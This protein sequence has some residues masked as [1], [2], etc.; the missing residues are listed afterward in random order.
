MKK[1]I[2]LAMLA[3]AVAGC[4]AKKDVVIGNDKMGYLYGNKHV[5]D[6]RDGEVN[7]IKFS[8]EGY[9]SRFG[10]PGGEWGN[11]LDGKSVSVYFKF[12]NSV[13][14][15]QSKESLAPVIKFLKM[16]GKQTITAEGN[17]D[18]RGAREYN[19]ALGQRRAE[20]VKS[21][22]VAQGVNPKQI[23]TMSFGE[24]RPECRGDGE[25][26]WAQNRRVTIKR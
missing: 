7:P 26:C 19:L 8:D 9:L 4:S 6:A 21:Y 23:D 17:C 2:V 3:L 11:N 10:V 1:Y 5:I 14:S 13:L 18:Q 24:E 16:D 12:D 25:A 22:L 20:A 15:D